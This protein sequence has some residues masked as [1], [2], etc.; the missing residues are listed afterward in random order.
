MFS[1][2]IDETTDNTVCKQLAICVSFV[3]EKLETNVDVL[4]IVTCPDGTAEGVFPS[5]DSCLQSLK[6][7]GVDLR[8]WVGFCADTTNTIMCINNSVATK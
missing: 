5:V 6:D 2:I 7:V 3:D 4:D 1:I 8:N